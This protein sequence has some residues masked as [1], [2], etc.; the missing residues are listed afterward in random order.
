[1]D[2]IIEQN[3]EIIFTTHQIEA[4]TG[5]TVERIREMQGNFMKIKRKTYDLMLNSMPDNPPEIGGIIGGKNEIISVYQIDNGM[6][7]RGCFYIPDVDM[8]NEVIENWEA[9]N[10]N[11]YGLFHTHFFD[12]KTLSEGDIKYIKIIMEAMPYFI[13]E[14]YFPIVVMPGRQMISYKAVKE[15]GVRIV[16]VNVEFEGY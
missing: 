6:N 14:L 2:I 5:R 12:V 13:K 1:M 9:E 11:F 10:I 15:D 7:P 8:L 16:K 3:E 4:N